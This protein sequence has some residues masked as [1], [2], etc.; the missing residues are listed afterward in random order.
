MTPLTT[1]IDRYLD[2]LRDQRAAP[3]TIESYGYSLTVIADLLPATVRGRPLAELG[4]EDLAAA[5]R[6]Y[7]ADKAASTV[8]FRHIVWTQMLVWATGAPGPIA[9]VPRPKKPKRLPR[10]LETEDG[11]DPMAAILEAAANPPPQHTARWPTRDV[12]LLVLFSKTGARV[13]DVLG[14]RD[15]QAPALTLRQV[16]EFVTFLGKG[17]KER[18]VPL[19]Q[20][21]R[22]L[23]GRYAQERREKLG[24]FSV[25]DP[26]FVRPDGQPLTH[27]NLQMLVDRIYK[28]SGIRRDQGG[29]LVHALRHSTAL[30]LA[31]NGVPISHL[32]A[33]LGHEN[34]RTTSTY[35]KARPSELVE[36]L[37]KDPASDTFAA[38]V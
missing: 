2:H 37:A 10:H 24:E 36:Q 19:D 1:T 12:A 35:L 27:R 5:F 20:V 15:G 21:V 18:T 4:S 26:L 11:S 38:L 23:I 7:G 3:A 32:A 17:D 29:A 22:T 16:G 25:D 9:Q 34:I 8:A 30:R 6:E 14:S 13:G 31:E 28:Q 33:L